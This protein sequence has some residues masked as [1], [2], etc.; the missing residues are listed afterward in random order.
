MKVLLTGATGFFGQHLSRRL[1]AD[2][3][4]VLPVSRQPGIGFDWSAS[5]LESGVN[6]SD[7][8]IHLAGENIFGKRWSRA[9]K[10][11]LLESRTLPTRQLAELLAKKGSGTL[12]S[13]SAVGYYG[14][15][16]NEELDENAPS[17]DDFL[18][19]VCREW[20]M[21]AQEP[22][23]GTQVRLATVRI[24]VILGLDG[25]ALKRMRLPFS[26][27]LG[28]PV[29][30]GRQVFPWI[31]VDDLARLFLFLLEDADACGPFNG[32]SPQAVSSAEFGRAF[33]RALRRPA[34]MPL[35]GFMLRLLL[36]ESANVLLSGQRAVPKRAQEAG[37]AFEHP[38][39]DE[40]LKHLVSAI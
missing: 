32:T 19:K 8:V 29:G 24:G 22:L 35:P 30:N 23:E 37:F 12:I 11:E 14:P 16:G 21:A 10:A 27:G 28:G 13:A 20:E 5:S 31:H 33:G 1:K 25:G 9:Q 7:A 40:A 36:G 17:G 4:E 3:H 2:G 6:A 15:R 34:F 26:L 18:A 38:N 39:L